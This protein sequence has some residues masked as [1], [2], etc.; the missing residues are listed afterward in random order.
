MNKPL[1]LRGRWRDDNLH[2]DSAGQLLGKSDPITFTL[3]GFELKSLQ[4]K[5]DKLILEGRRTGLELSD[6]KQVR[7]RLN[8]VTPERSDYESMRIE[9]AASPS[10]DYGPALDAIFANGLAELVPSMPSY[11]LPYALKNF[12]AIDSSSAPGSPVTNPPQQP[13][14]SSAEKP[15]HIGGGVVPPKLLS[16]KE[17][18]FSHAARA[19][20][21]SGVVVVHFWLHPDGTV[22]IYPSSAR[23][24]WAWMSRPW[25]PSRNTPFR[26]PTMNGKP[27]LVELNAE[28]NFQIF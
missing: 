12:T 21:Y 26:L 4:V 23:W 8:I 19:L 10:G 15:S 9:I 11:W 24:A 7:V 18:E 1:Y 25:P 5:H 3:C 14:D 22:S 20:K 2:F 16:C 28:V 6:H 27:V 17:P 13:A